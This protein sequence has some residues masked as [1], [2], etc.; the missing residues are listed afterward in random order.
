[1]SDDWCLMSIGRLTRT[2]ASSV[3]SFSSNFLQ[4]RA[5]ASGADVEMGQA[6][7]RQR[8][9]NK[10]QSTGSEVPVT[11]NILERLFGS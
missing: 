4:K 8:C 1:M 11:Q 7:L 9:T 5:D 2:G 3:L 10:P 6:G